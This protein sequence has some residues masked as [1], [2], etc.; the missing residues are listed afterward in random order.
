[1]NNSSEKVMHSASDA[2]NLSPERLCNSDAQEKNA[3]N[4][5][6]TSANQAIQ[7]NV[8]GDCAQPS[9][10]KRLCAPEAV[11]AIKAADLEGIKRSNIIRRCQAGKYP[12]AYKTTMNGGP[13]WMIPVAS[14]SP[15]AQA[16]YRK[17]IRPPVPEQKTLPAIVQ[18][19]EYRTLM[20]AYDKKPPNLK[21]MAV[22][23]AAAVDAFNELRKT[24]LS[25]GAAEKSIQ[26]SHKV[27]KPALCRYR[28]AVDGHDRQYWEAY[29]CPR[30]HGG[31]GKS[32]FSPEA[33]EAIIK[34]FFV[35]SQPPLTAILP[36]I[37]KMASERGWD[38]P[39][40]KTV[41]NR[42]NAE[43]PHYWTYR[44]GGKKALERSFPTVEKE[45]SSLRLHEFWESDG[46]RADVW[47]IWPDG[48]IGRPVV[49][50]WREVRT[51]MPLA[52][53]IYKNEDSELIISA[54]CNALALTGTRPENAKLDNGRS[55]ANKR[56]TGQQKNR[57][58]FT[59]KPDEPIGLLT[60]IG[61]KV[62]WSKPGRGRDK[63]IE[64]WWN[65]MAN[66]CD[67]LPQFEGAY[68]GRNPVE[69][70]DN[71]DP[72][73]AVPV[74]EYADALKEAAWNFAN[75][76]HRGD[77]MSG[78]SPFALY[79]RLSEAHRMNPVDP[80]VLRLG[81]M[82]VAI[83]KPDQKT[84][85]LS[86]KVEG[87]GTLRYWSDALAE[88]PKCFRARKLHVYYDPGN[89]NTPVSVYDGDKHLCDAERQGK[90]DFND[91]GGGK[92]EAH[93]RA[94]A[95]F[96][97]PRQADINALKGGGDTPNRPALVQVEAM[98]LITYFDPRATVTKKPSPARPEPEADT[99]KP[100][101]TEPGA[102]QD[103]ETGQVYRGAK[104]VQLKQ[105]AVPDAEEMSDE[106]IEALRQRQREK[107]LPAHLRVQP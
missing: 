88:L 29:L 106:E 62:K 6:E 44:Q 77:G 39:S 89:P 38:I 8:S 104:V 35:Q 49:V 9:H 56:F 92:V 96:L 91:V 98:P 79:N 43:K 103:S 95:A 37:R 34:D 105:K 69:K 97:K 74:E 24:G 27:S 94:Q 75:R 85:E 107:N 83:V 101:P 2:H 20:D 70:P 4:P 5:I 90:V 1:M 63:P 102:Y 80:A 42:L 84:G 50:A 93:M 41:M 33:Y 11:T 100:H 66:H 59:I 64:S 16:I 30:Y 7:Q 21:R 78:E 65:F 47:C 22:S 68:C 46:R 31:R 45:Y 13:G 82:G 48:S 55:F 81:L 61:T 72:S 19:E 10:D 87:F 26:Q 40:D 99:I 53:G 17:E 23:A 28:A 86:F 58:R 60:R 73:K 57:Y 76:S 67:K 3:H 15:A 12:D 54:F 18:H 51:R 32:E 71:F 52:L 25:V 14:L 36:R